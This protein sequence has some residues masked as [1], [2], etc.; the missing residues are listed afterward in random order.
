MRNPNPKIEA[1]L[2]IVKIFNDE[3]VKLKEARDRFQEAEMG[4]KE[5]IAQ[6]GP[7]SH[8]VAV[9]K[10]AEQKALTCLGV[11][12][13]K[14][15]SD[16]WSVIAV[17]PK[18]KFQIYVKSIFGIQ[19][20]PGLQIKTSVEL[21]RFEIFTEEWEEQHGSPLN[22]ALERSPPCCDQ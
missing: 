12:P 2:N 19:K 15:E 21:K 7:T 22:E 14:V 8:P 20:L 13:K 3:V 18:Q 1:L 6:V 5:I 16:G 4:L 17:L 11:T 9:Y 10:E